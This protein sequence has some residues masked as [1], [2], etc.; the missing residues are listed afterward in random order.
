MDLHEF[1]QDIVSGDWVLFA[2]GRTKRPHAADGTP[3]HQPQP[4]EDCVFE[5][6][7]QQKLIWET[8]LL[9]IIENKY[10]LVRSEEYVPARSFGPFTI[11]EAIGEH[12]VV[13][14]KDHDKQLHQ[15]SVEE[16]TKVVSAY[17]KRHRE[18]A[19]NAAHTRYVMVFHNFGAD[20]GA[21]VWHPH[22]QII[23][24]PIIPP[25]IT[26]RLYGARK[27]FR[28]HGK[29]VHAALVAWE[30]AQGKRI[31]IENDHF[32]VLAPYASKH[33]AEIRI[34]PTSFDSHFTQLPDD[35]DAALAQTLHD[36]LGK[37][38]KVLGEPSY[39]FY[40]HSAPEDPSFGDVRD[41]YAWHI[42]I[43]PKVKIDAGVELGTGIDVNVIDP[44]VFA[45]QLRNA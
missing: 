10:P 6:L 11:E 16:L 32:C 22:S 5:D 7:T 41:F 13:V 26:R 25:A 12:D 2:T 33:S 3:L 38:M 1:R 42:E 18:I 14:Y 34:Y 28:E 9:A 37:M 44:D 15:F 40:V 21:S 36:T 31:I 43:V 8:D 27:Y 30:R 17:K 23:G 35:L 39:N 4:K 45:E 29:K 19:Q 24:L 20:V